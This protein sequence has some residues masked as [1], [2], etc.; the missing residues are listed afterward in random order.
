MSPEISDLAAS[1]RRHLRAA[2]KADRTL[3][4]YGQ[5]IRFFCDW[6]AAQGRPTT[7]DQ[8]HRHAVS[9][10]LADLSER[11]DVE[12]VR[13]RLRGMRRF[14]RWLVAEGELDK[15]PTEGVE[16]PARLD[17][18]V[19]VLTD[20]E[21]IRLLKQCAVARGRA[22]VFDRRIFDGRRDEVIIRLLTDCGLRVS[23]LVSLT[24]A[25]S[26]NLDQELLYVTGKGSRPRI[27]PYGAR[28]G[29]AIDRYLRVRSAHPYA[30][31]GDKLL[32]GERGPL[33][34]D[35]VRWRLELLGRAAQVPD[36]HPHAFRHTFAHRWLANG[37]Q[38]R[39]LMQLAGWRSDAM[40]SVYARSTAVARAQDSHRRL[41]LGDLI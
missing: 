6:L 26:L 12:T 19:R 8:L 28:T 10:W 41:A 21:L 22:G 14:A 20:E 18:P 7:L 9:A 34:A 23:E 2:G 36:L 37:G 13:T 33:S 4:L 3:T 15:A 40:L 32:L 25:D 17:K 31:R 24:V 30:G 27:V 5:S 1:F 11:V 29:Q 38:E 39:D 16:M 35:G